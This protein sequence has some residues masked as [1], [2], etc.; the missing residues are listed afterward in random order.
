MKI[1]KKQLQRIIREATVET[2]AVTDPAI[3]F[4]PISDIHDGTETPESF[5]MRNPLPEDDKAGSDDVLSEDDYWDEDAG[6]REAFLDSM[7]EM[8]LDHFG[9]S[10]VDRVSVIHAL[11]G[12]YQDLTDENR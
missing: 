1:T 12:V 7:V 11:N 6:N 5:R 8:W 3:T 4:K 9:M 10:G 2:P